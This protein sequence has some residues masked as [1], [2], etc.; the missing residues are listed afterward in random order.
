MVGF[1]A[2]WPHGHK[3]EIKVYYLLLTWQNQGQST[4]Q[5]FRYAFLKQY[6]ELKG[7]DSGRG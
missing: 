6:C 7:Q 3:N 4:V 2:I 1:Y 5:W